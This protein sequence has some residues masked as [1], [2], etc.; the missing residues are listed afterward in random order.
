MDRRRY[1]QT[2]GGGGL[3]S[4]G[5]C[6]GTPARENG[7]EL[8][9]E[10]VTL[11]AGTTVHDSGLLAALNAGF[12][13]WLGVSVNAVIRGSGGALRTARNGD[14]DLVLVHA[15]PLEDEF[16]R[17]GF[18]INRRTVMVNDFLVV[19]P[20]DDPAGAAGEDPVSAFEAIAAAKAP[21]LSRGDRSGTHLRERQ[22]WSEAGITPSGSW[23]R[24]TGQGM[25]NTLTMA[26]EV[27]GYTLAERGSFLTVIIGRDLV[28]L[29]DRGIDDPPPLLRNEYAI[30]PVNTAR[31]DVAYSLAMAYV[32]YVTG[33]GQERIDDSRIDGDRAYRPLG[34]SANP[35]FE[36]YIPSDWP[37]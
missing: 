22:L 13:D 29:V 15:R 23:Y 24:E 19:G 35:R 11:A 7:A 6:T 32:G 10:K 21:F 18:G 36:Q 33:P 3:L 5:G 14:C 28:A 2:I 25:G 16:I 27:G 31:R 4:L 20:S 37:D 8:D 30:I 17:Q 9:T 1:L 12:E 26:A 34:R